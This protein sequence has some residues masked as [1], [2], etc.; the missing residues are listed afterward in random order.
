M[1]VYCKSFGIE[2]IHI[3]KLEYMKP[4]QEIDQVYIPFNSLFKFEY[5]EEQQ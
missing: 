1:Y 4:R 5:D 2:N 3:N